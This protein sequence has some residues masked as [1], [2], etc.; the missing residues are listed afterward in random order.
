MATSLSAGIAVFVGYF[1]AISQID[2]KHP[3][4]GAGEWSYGLYLLHAPIV[5]LVFRVAAEQAWVPRTAGVLLFA[6]AL[7]FL[8]GSAFGEGEWRFYRWSQR[9]IK[10]RLARRA[11][12]RIVDAPAPPAKAA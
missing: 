7:A 3:L 2:A 12:L 5:V 9:Q 1:A 4:A 8:V 10:N 6:G 11:A